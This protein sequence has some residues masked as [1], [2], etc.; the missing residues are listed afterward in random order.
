MLF[1]SQFTDNESER[2]TWSLEERSTLTSSGWPIQAQWRVSPQLPAQ[3]DLRSDQAEIGLLYK[4]GKR[5]R[6]P[7][8]MEID[9][10]I[11]QAQSLSHL[12]SLLG[13]NWIVRLTPHYDG[14]IGETGTR[15]GL[16]IEGDRGS[17]VTSMVYMRA[18]DDIAYWHTLPR[19]ARPQVIALS[20]VL[21]EEGEL[22]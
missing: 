19:L 6:S 7:H 11:D 4:A 9:S 12:C 13:I 20:P 21:E 8:L 17:S 2:E 5:T 18:E 15:W 22:R 1:A 14:S 10:L 3:D 16:I